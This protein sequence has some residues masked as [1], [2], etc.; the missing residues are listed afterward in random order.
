MRVRSAR[1]VISAVK[2]EGGPEGGLPEIAL[3]G[4]S[5]VGKS[6]LIN[7]LVG[8]RQLARTGQTPGKTRLL[9]FYCVNEA[10]MLVDLPG[11]G[12][13]K[14]SAS[15]R[16]SW[17]PMVECY[18]AARHELRG[19]MLVLDIRR[20]P[21]PDE[22]GLLARFTARGL[23]QRVLLTKCDKLSR[24][25]QANRRKLVARA[26]GLDPAA[27]ILFSAWTRQGI[28]ETWAAIQTMLAA[29]LPTIESVP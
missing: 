4:R 27:L 28:D 13:A 29:E 22:I 19:V 3:A 15:E 26:L 2:P 23:A 9:N 18:L 10:L 11:Y 7:T 12:Y 21:G 6:S 8:R 17:G 5:N 20:D 24:N 14:V 1:F 16:R 25:G